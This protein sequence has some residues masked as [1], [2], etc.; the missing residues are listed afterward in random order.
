MTDKEALETIEKTYG[1]DIFE[2][3]D[4]CTKK[5]ITALQITVPRN[6]PSDKRRAMRFLYEKTMERNGVWIPIIFVE[7]DARDSA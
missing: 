6:F 2:S 4:A 3:M 7:Q 5:L 1:K